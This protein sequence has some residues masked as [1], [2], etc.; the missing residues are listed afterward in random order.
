MKEQESIKEDKYIICDAWTSNHG[1]SDTLLGLIKYFEKNFDYISKLV[2][3]PARKMK[4]E[5][6][7]FHFPDRE[8]VVD[9]YGD[10]SPTFLKWLKAA[11]DTNAKIIFAACRTGQ[12]QKNTVSRIAAANGYKV[13]WYSNLYWPNSSNVTEKKQKMIRQQEIECLS[14]LA[15]ML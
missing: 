3:I 1:K 4:D 14:D 2:V 12:S 15:H 6:L 7:L 5:L 8:V 9:T 13:I 11:V 10:P